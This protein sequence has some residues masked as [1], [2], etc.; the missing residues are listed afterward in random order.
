M[1]TCIN[2]CV[3]MISLAMPGIRNGICNGCFYSIREFGRYIRESESCY[4][5]GD[6]RDTDQRVYDICP[7]FGFDSQQTH[8][9]LHPDLSIAAER[10]R[11]ENSVAPTEARPSWF[12]VRAKT[13]ATPS[14]APDTQ[15][16]PVLRTTN[17]ITV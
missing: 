15:W 10:L 12:S 6:L 3:L 8:P 9:R 16:R 11:K 13:D 14:A 7:S 2:R 17:K 4:A 1:T 5:P